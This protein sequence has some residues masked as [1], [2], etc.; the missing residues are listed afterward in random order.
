MAGAS[1]TIDGGSLSGG[2]VTGGAG[3]AGQ[4]RGQNG[5]AFGTGIFLQ[6]N[7]VVTF[8]P[9][10]GTTETISDVIADQRSS[11]SAGGT[12]GL[13][14][15]G[16][17]TL[18]LNAANSFAGGVTLNEGAL[19]LSDSTSAGFGAI[20]FTTDAHATLE[21]D[22]G[23]FAPNLIAGFT[24]GDTID[25]AGGG[26][27]T[28]AGKTGGGSIVMSSS[29]GNQVL[30]ESGSSLRSTISGFGVSDEVDFE[31]VEYYS[32]DTVGY[33]G[34]VVSVHN[35]KGTIV[36]SFYVSGT[37]TSANFNVGADASGHVLVTYAG[38]AGAGGASSADLLGRYGSQFFTSIPETHKS[39]FARDSLLAP[40][41]SAETY[42]GN[43]A[44]HH[45]GNAWDI[46]VSSSGPLG[47]GPGPGS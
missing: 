44:H 13:I 12:G 45:E 38:T 47:R 40:V 39:V 4:Y 9:A 6:G 1:L 43:L 18:D 31:A 8:A 41:S 2:S 35:S 28:L 30:L 5:Q 25:F 11:G 26:S 22:G 3:G 23:V 14:L 33:L 42:T 46:G 27:A 7:E 32:T 24:K 21:L 17:G 15:D 19:E 16:L 10:R 29:G 34:G 37:Y 20:I 36:A